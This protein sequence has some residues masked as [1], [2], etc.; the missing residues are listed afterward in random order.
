M[1]LIGFIIRNVVPKYDCNYGY[2]GRMV[3]ENVR[4]WTLGYQ[5]GSPIRITQFQLHISPIPY[6]AIHAFISPINFRNS[7]VALC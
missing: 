7:L 1:H 3:C 5:G 4:L 2:F 6:F